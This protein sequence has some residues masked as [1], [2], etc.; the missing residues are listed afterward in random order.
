MKKTVFFIFLLFII[1]CYSSKKAI[2]DL[3]SGNYDTSINQSIKKLKGNKTKKNLQPF[4]LTLEQAFAKAQERDLNTI[5]LLEKEGY[6]ANTEKIFKTYK[7]LNY[8]QEKIKPLLPLPVYN[9]KSNAVFKFNDYSNQLA[10]YKTKLTD[11][12][13]KNALNLIRTGK[14]K[15]DYR[16]AYE[17]LKY[18]QKLNPNYKNVNELTEEALYKGTNFVLVKITN[19]THQII[20]RRLENDLLNFDTYGLNNQ[21]TIYHANKAPNTHYDYRM[22]IALRRINISPES[23]KKRHIVREKEIKDGWKY[24]HNTRNEIKKDSLGNKIK[25]PIYKTVRCNV[26]EFTQTKFT[27]IDGVVRYKNL[28]NNQQLKSFPIS[29]E[30]F[31]ENIYANYKGDKRALGNNLLTLI[32]QNRIPFPSNEQMVYDTGE[33]LKAKIKSIILQQRL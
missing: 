8:R 16:D 32:N 17:D 21:W 14:T 33:D 22:E 19:K 24:L 1:G 31:F 23:V 25:V 2:K 6:E 11:Y 30:Y 18:L 28:N 27:K 7:K 12:L 29:S 26:Y 9:R 15:N 3:N 10:L 5:K 13:Y 20:P 4:V